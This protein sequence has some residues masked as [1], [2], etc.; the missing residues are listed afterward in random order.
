MYNIVVSI[1][2]LGILAIFIKK[3]TAN[4]EDYNISKKEIDY[5]N[6]MVS[7]LKNTV[8]FTTNFK[9]KG[10]DGIDIKSKSLKGLKQ[11]NDIIIKE[12]EVKVCIN[13]PL[14]NAYTF[15]LKA[16]KKEGITYKSLAT[17]I[18]THYH[19][20]YNKENKESKKKEQSILEETGGKI[21]MFNRCT[22]DGP[23][24]IWGHII[25]DLTL[26]GIN[27]DPFGKI[28]YPEIES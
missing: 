23:Y 28:V 25:D 8:L 14:T 2:I 7:K 16:D 4:K 19:I 6:Q 10:S 5:Q 18:V 22:T 13:Y 3:M 20:V 27:Y 26:T 12:Q 21:P 11:S 17:A 1:V 9:I 15:N 24:G